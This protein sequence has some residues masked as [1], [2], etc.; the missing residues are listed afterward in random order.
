MYET[1]VQHLLANGDGLF[2]KKT[3]K[4]MKRKKDFVVF[5]ALLV[6]F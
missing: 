4:K 2:N 1:W 5:I 6:D 3:G